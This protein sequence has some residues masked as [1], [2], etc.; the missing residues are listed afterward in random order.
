MLEA[1]EGIKILFGNGLRKNNKKQK[2]QKFAL[3]SLYMPRVKLLKNQS[4]LKASLQFTVYCYNSSVGPYTVFYLLFIFYTKGPNNIIKTQMENQVTIGTCW[5]SVRVGG[6]QMCRC[7]QSKLHPMRAKHS[8]HSC[9][10]SNAHCGTQS[11]KSLFW[12]IL[13][14]ELGPQGH[15]LT[16]Q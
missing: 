16:S 4:N 11:Y 2:L 7:T 10:L 12:Q 15:T 1:I 13:L 3:P 14:P 8:A 6:S 9:K 5:R